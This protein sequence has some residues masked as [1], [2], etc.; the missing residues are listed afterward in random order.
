MLGEHKQKEA[1]S[2]QTASFAFY[3][4]AP[5]ACLLFLSDQEKNY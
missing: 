4:S 5:K 2:T 3:R 1:V